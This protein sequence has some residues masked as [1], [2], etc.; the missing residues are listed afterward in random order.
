M[1]NEIKKSNPMP[2]IGILFLFV[3]VGMRCTTHSYSGGG[4]NYHDTYTKPFRW[5]GVP[6]SSVHEIRRV[7]ANDKTCGTMYDPSFE[8]I[9]NQG[10]I[11][12]SKWIVYG[13][14]FSESDKTKSEAKD[15]ID[16]NCY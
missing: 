10:A 8:E 9:D 3:A 7:D 12:P 13:M 6:N 15:L 1:E 16:K 11:L 5:Y 2:F 4:T 14:G